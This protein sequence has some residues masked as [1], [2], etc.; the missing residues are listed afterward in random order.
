MELNCRL[1]VIG[2]WICLVLPLIVSEATAQIRISK[3]SLTIDEGGKG[4]YKL[5]LDA[6]PSTEI[7]LDITTTNSDVRV[8]PESLTFTSNGWDKARKITV[9]AIKDADAEDDRATVSHSVRVASNR[10]RVSA[11]PQAA[12]ATAPSSLT[13][14]VLDQFV[15][16]HEVNIS[17]SSGLS[18]RK[19]GSGNYSVSLTE[20]PTASVTVWA[21]SSRSD[22]RVSPSSRT[23]YIGTWNSTQSFTVSVDGDATSSSATIGHSATSGDINYQGLII[24]SLPITVLQPPAGITQ[25]PSTTKLLVGQTKTYFSPKLRSQ[26]TQTVTINASSQATG[27]ARVTESKS[28]GT[29]AWN[30]AQDFKVTGQSPGTTTITYDVDSSD[31]R[32]DG[33]RLSSTSV[34]VEATAITCGADDTNIQLGGSSTLSWDSTNANSVTINQGVGSVP[35]DSPGGGKTVTPP[36]PGASET[37]KATTYRF[38]AAGA[39]DPGACS[40]TIT[41]WRPPSVDRFSADPTTLRKQQTTRLIWATSHAAS[42]TIDQGVGSVSVD[43]SGQGRS[44][45]P[46][47]PSTAATSKSTSYTLKASNPGYTGSSA[48]RATVSVTVWNRPTVDRFSASPS[49][50]DEGEDSGLKWTTTHAT[51]VSIDQGVG[52]VS[53]DDETGSTKVSPHQDTTYTL[54]ASNPGYT[55]THAVTDTVRVTVSPPTVPQPPA[56]ITQP[57]SRT[58]VLVGQTKTYYSP[59]LR[60]QPTGTV[61]INASSQAAGNATVTGSKSFSSGNW[62]TAQDFNLTGRSVGTATITYDV[63][64]SDSRYDSYRLSSTSVTVEAIAIT[65]GADDTNIQLGGSSTLSW[66]STNANSVTINQGVGS[67]PLDSPGGGKTVTPPQPGASETSK[68]TTYRFT[69]A[70]A[71]DP[72]ACSVTITVWRP[73]SV[74]RFSADLTTLRKQQTTRLSWATGHASSTSI[75]QGIGS[76]SVDSSGGG[77]SVTP[78]QPST[79]ATSKSTSYTLTA[80][81]PGYTG[82]DAASATVSVTV[83]NRPSVDRFSASPSTIDEGEDSGLKWTTTHATGVSI[84]QG[85][86]SVSVDD[87]T[88]STKVSPHQDTTYTL[89]ASNPGYTGTHAVTDTVR[90]TVSP[91]TV[92]QP[93]AGITQPPSRTKV[94]VGQTKTYYSPA[95]RSQPTGTVTIN[96]SSQAAGNATVTGSKSF[97]SGNWNTAQDFNLTGRSVGTATITYDVDSSDSRYDGYRLSSTSVTVEATAITCG[98]DDTNIQLGGSSTLSWDSTNANS[99]TINQGVGSVPLDSPGGG[100]T[101]TPPQPGASETSKATTYRFTAAGAGDP[102][103]CSVTITVWRPPSVD[104]FSADLTT[105]R[106][107]QTT[108]LSWATGHA[109]STSINQGIGSVS[110]DSSGGGRSVTPLQPSTAATSKS[111]SYTLTA[112][113]PGYTGTDAASA[114]VSVT[115]WNRPTVDR[116]S[117][118]PSTIDEGEDSGLKWTT[119]HATGV[120][121]DQG[122]G[123][124]SVDDETGSTKVSPHQDTT[125]TL[126]ASNPGYTGT[127]AVTD[128][129][130]VTVSPPT[131]PQPPAGITQPPSRTKVLV[132][133]TKTYYSPALRSQPTGTVT[134]NASSQAAGNATVTGSKSFSSG[135]WN[136]AQDFNLTGRS[137]GTATITYDVDSSDSR[138][139]GYRLSSTSVTVEATAITCGADDTNIQLGGSSTLSWDSTNANSVTINQGVGSVPLDSPGGGKTVTPP[140]PGASETSKATT[141]RFTAAGAGDP[142]ACSVTITVWRRPSVDRFS[143]DPTT[144]RK[145]QATRLSWATSH[146]SGTSINQ[147]IGSVSV[148][149]SGGGRSVTPLQPSTAATSKRTSYTLTASNPGYAGTDATRATV[150]VTVWN[151]PSVDRFT[152][153]PSTIDEGEDSGLKWTT[154]H[155]TGVSIDQGVGPVAVDDET[156]TTKVSPHQDRTYTLTA[157]NPAYTGT[158]A[159]T[160]TVRV[161]VLPPA[162]PPGLSVFPTTLNIT[163]G[164]AGKTYN[165]RLRTQPS[166]DVTVRVEVESGGDSRVQKNTS[167][168]TFTTADWNRNQAVQVFAEEKSGTATGQARLANTPPSSYGGSAVDVTVNV[169]DDDT[170]GCEATVMPTRLAIDEGETNGGY[171]DVVLAASPAATVTITLDLTGDPSLSADRSALTFTSGNWNTSQRV[172][173]EAREDADYSDGR[174]TIGHTA[175]STDEGCSGMSISSVSVNIRDDDEPPPLP[176]IT[177]SSDEAGVS[178]PDGTAM[179]TAAVASGEEPAGDLTINL[180]HSGQATNGTDYTVATLTIGS[181]ETSDNAELSVIDDKFAEGTEE[182]RLIANA[183]GYRDSTPLSM[184]LTD[185]DSAGVT[186]TPT[187]LTIPE[188]GGLAY[189]VMLTS[190]PSHDVTVTVTHSGDRDIG[191][192]DQELTFTDSDW[193]TAR[194]VTVTAAQDDDAIDDTAIF[195]HSVASTDTDYN[196][197]T[198]SEVEVTVTDDETAGVSIAPAELS[199]AEGG[200]D[201]YE[202]VLTSKPSHEV[203]V[204]ISRSGDGDI[205]ID[206]QELT[207]TDSDWETAQAVTVSAAQDEDAIDDTA[208]FSHSVASTDTNYNRITVSEVAVTVTDDEMAGVSI[209][210]R[211][212]TIAEG[213]IDSYQVVLTSQPAHDVTI[214]ITHSG[215]GDIGIDDQELTFTDSDWETAQAVTVAAAQDD[216]AR[217]D[218]ATLSHSV[219]ST[220]TDYNGIGVSEV[221]VTATD[222]E[223]AGVSITPRQLTIAEGGIDS[224]QVVLTSQPAH[225][226]TVN[227]NHGGDN[228]IDSDPDRLTFSPSNWDQEKTVSVRAAQDDDARDDTATFS[229]RLDST[230]GDYNGITVSEVAVAVTDDETAGVSI[231]PEELTIAEGASDSYEVFLTSQ[232]SHDVTVTITHSRDGDISIDDQ[233]LTF[234]GSDWE[235]AQTVTVAAAQDDDARDDTATLSHSVASTDGDY[236]G[237]TVSEVAVAV[238]DDE[239]AGVSILPEELTIAEGASDSYEVVLT[240]QPAHEVTVTITH[241]GDGDI[242]I[243]DQELTFTGSDWETPQAVT[244]SAAQD[245]DARDAAA[246]LSHSVAS[247]DTDYNEIGVSEVAVAVTDDETAGVSIRPE[248]LTIAEGGSDS[249]QVVLTSKPAHDVTVTITHSGDGDINSDA[250]RLTFASSDWNQAQTVAVTADQDEDARDDA[251]TLSH[252]VASTDTDYNGITV[253]AVAVTAADDETAGVTIT[254]T[255]LTIAEGGSDAYQVVLTSQPS[256]EVTVTITHSGDGDINSDADRLT[257]AS[258]DW[259]QAQTVAVTADQD[260]DARDDAATLSHSVASTDTDYNGIGVSEVAVAVTDDE[261]AGVSILPEELTIAEGGSDAY[262]VVLTSQPA[263]EV[264]VTITHSGDGDISIGDQELTF[265]D[266]DW[267]T[268]QAVTVSADQDEDARDDTATLSHS[269]ASTDGDYNGITV[270]EVA[271]AVTDDETAGVSILPEELTIAEGGSD[272]YQ[273]FLMSQPAHD[274]TVT[275]SYSGDQDVSID[276][277]E[278]TFTGSDWETAQTVT[279]SAAQDDDARDDTAIL[280]H[281][282]ASTDTDYNGI[283]VSEVAVAVTDD[284]TAGVS[285]RPEE[286][287]IAEGA[288]DSY[289][290]FLTSQ[291]SHD[292]TVTITHSRDGDISIDDQELTFTGSD[293]ETAQ[294]VTVAAAQDDD[295]RD[296]T[297]TLSHSVASTDGDYNGITV[298]EVAVAVTDDET[299]GVSILPEELTIAEGASDSYEVVLTSQPAH[300]VTVTITHSGDGDISIDDQELTFTGSDWET[301]Q[302]VTVSAAQDDDARDAAATLSHSVAS[303]DTDYNEIGVSEVAVAVTDDETAGVSILPEEL[304]I[305]EGGSDSYQVVLTSKPAHDVTVT[306]THSG[307]GDIN[308]DADRLTFASSDWNQAQTVAVTADQDEDAR[309]DAATLSHSV[310]STD[311]DYNGIGV[312]EV[313]VAV[314]DDETAGVSILPEELTI[315]EGGSD[316]YQVVLTS[317]PAH[318]VTVTITHSGDGDISIGDQELTFT[319]SD[320]AT[321]QA[322]TVSADQD[323]DARDDTATLSHSVASTDGDYNG[324]TVSEVAVAVTDDE[325]A[326][327]SILPEELTIAEGGSDSYQVFLMSQPAHDVTVTISYSG[328]QDVSID[329]QELTFTGSDWETAQ[330]VTVSAAQD[331]DARDDTAILSHSVASTDTDYNGIGVSE[332]A[333]AVTDDETAGVSILP[334]ELTIAEG[335]SDSYQ[336]FL[337]SQPAHDVTVTISYSGD[338]DVSIDDQELTFTGSDWETAQTVTVSAAQDDDARD[339]TA[340]L[341]HSVAST[342]TDYNGIGVSEVAVAVTDDETAGVS[343]LPEE[344]TIAE[345]GSDSYQVVLTSQPAHKVTVTITHSGDGDIGIDDQEL[346]FTASNWET[347]QAVTVSADQDEDARDDTATLSHSVASTDGDYNGITVSEVAVAVTDDETAGV[348]I[349]P[350]ELT[351]AEGASDSYEVVLT[352]QPAHEVTVTITHSG[353]GDIS[354]DDQELTFTGS[355][356][357]TPQAVTVSAAQDDDAR[358]A[359]ATLSHSV[360]STDT[361]YNEIGVSEVAVAVT[362]D[363][364]AGVSIRPEEL[365]IAEGGSDSYQVVLTSKPAHDVT[366][367]ITHSGDGDINSDADRLTF[368]SSDWNQAQTVAVTADQD[369]DA[370][371]DAAT[372]SHSVASTDTDYNGITVSAVAVTAADD[373]TAGV[374]I[375]PTQLTIAEG[376]SDAYQVVLTSQPSHEVTVTITHSGDGDI[377]S[378]ADRLTFASSDWNQAQTVAVT[379]DQDEDARD[380]AATLSHSVASTDT[381]YN[382]IGVSEVA[383]AVTDDETAGVSILPEELTIAEGGSDSYQ[384]FLMSQPAHDVTVTISYSGDQ[385]VSIDDQELTFTGSDWET[386]QTVT[387]SAAQDDD[388]RDDSA[389]LSHSVASTDTD[390]NGITVS[391]VA[392]AVTDDETA[393]VSILP[394]EL[395]I[396]EGAS[397]SYEVVLT[398]QPA[399]EVTVTITHSGDGDI[400][401]DDQELA[402]TASDWETPQAVT[403]SAAQDDDARDDSATL[404]HSVSSTDGDYNGVTVSEVAVA[405]TDDETAGVSIRPTDLTIAEGGSDRY[406]VVLTSQPAHE[407]TVTITHSGDGDIGID[408]QELAFTASDWETP[409]AVT[410][411]AAQDDDAR[412]DTATLSHVVASADGDYNG[413][414]V[415]EVAVTAT[416]DETAG[417][418]I[419]PEE[420]T[421]AEGGSDSYQVVLTS[422]PAHEVTVTVTHSGDQDI[423]IGDQELTFTASD[424]ETPQ[425]VTVAAAQDDDARDDTATLS[426]SVSSTDGDYNGVT[427][428]AVNVT[429]RDDET[430]GVSIRPEELTIA[431]GGSDSYEVALTS[432]PSHEVTVTI[433]HGGDADIDSAPDRLTFSSSDWKQKKTV[434]VRATQDDDARDDTATLSHSVSSTDG[435][436]NGVTVS[437]VNVTVRDDETPGVSIRPEE[438]TIAEGGSDS[439]EVALTSK[440]SH[441]V[442]VTITH[443]G[444]ADIDSAPDRLTF[445]SSDWKQKKTVTVRAT[446]DDDARDDAAT[447]S[448]TVSSTDGDYNGI[449]VSEVAVTATDDETA[450]VS[451]LPEELTIAEGGSDSYQVVLTSQPAHEV[452]VTVTHSGDQDIGIGDQELTFTAS[453]WETPQAVTVAAAQDDDAREDTATLSHSVAS[454][455][456]DY[457]EISVSAVDVTATDDETAG[458]SIT[459][460]ELTI[461]EGG[462]DSYEVVLTSQPSHDVTVTISRSGDRHISID[463]QE[464]TFTESDW[465]PAEDRYCQQPPKTTMPETTRRHSATAWPAPMGTTTGLRFRKW[466]SPSPTTRPPAYRSRQPN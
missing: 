452:T 249:Y 19:G 229:H 267:A 50:I 35:L 52:S 143:A 392:V 360:A 107:Q 247:T 406:E 195:S 185:D 306:I 361:D 430:P 353:D 81:N 436:Y 205:G 327:V 301:P 99:V 157:S 47:Q 308:S 332:V 447:L 394:E 29:G 278:L 201:S 395:T 106:K 204:T 262:Q 142:G 202:V 453:N 354:I 325:T 418:S 328:D 425:A 282:V 95:L 254:P 287:T 362:D 305:A 168:L 321:P 366:V 194:T 24:D 365:T 122:V 384:V 288:S 111:T 163:E 20:R 336:V 373:E 391:E 76:V 264:T 87:E 66:D 302:A 231:R 228:D 448:H 193:E 383:V 113:N 216:D 276:D 226:V 140:Q 352:S 207:F 245:D 429:V 428:S 158:Q 252:S 451:I 68:A 393:G 208:T 16:S 286:L 59:A 280:S 311:T 210:P 434:T 265:T 98:A 60:S 420:L 316:A 128:T 85:V 17:P 188:G 21:S 151:R 33:Y 454:T 323:E 120:S 2:I 133:Q 211:Q 49:T 179:V 46:P 177:L 421:I 27:T 44:V 381:D 218:T 248:E 156:G 189:R 297:A 54:T 110:V 41:V 18:I 260:E 196:G 330:T 427:V 9:E 203:T 57:P 162:P 192:D 358:D 433:T 214:T 125:Y 417:V 402:F 117:A 77:R 212:L 5:Y 237:I 221:E 414:T 187:S 292:V 399:H 103:A 400:G 25:P 65:C 364:T 186:V 241:S 293:W 246:T 345:G 129:V 104:R 363:E 351:I 34:T 413:I 379:A 371:D 197:I 215:D 339:D 191:I 285:I 223:M 412:D 116:F 331:D 43:S 155:A 173:I 410:V 411:S 463:D 317:Q 416:D 405:V 174:A 386:A 304:T 250:D 102:G 8:K 275:I 277:Q 58:K 64:S 91:P 15:P 390:Y 97:S 13:V 23:F 370:R 263:H 200:S 131:V 374:T 298:S 114:T 78:L 270:S 466:T 310:A 458:V 56:G 169:A 397:D 441:E 347:A 172:T 165:V 130:R 126:T 146:A 124:V 30:T 253:S 7:T 296:D 257:F 213:G 199:I 294:T 67:V 167:S 136:T 350:E 335:G 152:A 259:N 14:I 337:M 455:D 171:Y 73:P 134:I 408:D 349:L 307:D 127:H 423:G 28:F 388:A 32:Y 377:N 385:D 368:A 409:Q 272:S 217:D 31:S 170:D 284:E 238:T 144:L 42:T 283:G 442:T 403:V 461:A 89:A 26:P 121:I 309:D 314:T 322:V 148:D 446:Q 175:S 145:Q 161:T 36:Q 80:S 281:S 1:T 445:S 48:A 274:V 300:E 396:A 450:G 198:V 312:S 84:D 256:H 101:V 338:Q 61:T 376:G 389:T 295:A 348:S 387:V 108:R 55:G 82:T 234:T 444:D 92:P 244:V 401:I 72:G 456:G 45:S 100:K 315:A 313:A 236:N 69:A 62:N 324:I 70:G 137:V 63:D 340:I 279:V 123:S 380:D 22:V 79:A 6:P 39:G 422:Q 135:N 415:S 303:T 94:L 240:S 266:S 318:E 438:L 3:S 93:P 222:D 230:D 153:S 251:A 112:S 40:V 159:V 443:G 372:L 407:V 181:G 431:E 109:S 11:N 378:D 342:D 154:T 289:E 439:Y 460:T 147:G 398:S 243:D 320:W 341:S 261:T 132:G 149:S 424:W 359:A 86:G 10:R 319:D 375:T 184:N 105:L 355:D 457:N 118:S 141:Y 160:D 138:Y 426:H 432:K 150:S 273:V 51:G 326:G 346:A 206:D 190:R 356:W 180:T 440:P 329:D 239:T 4:S 291:P 219:A 242:S 220:D 115:V 462:S 96:A 166:R 232:P 271:V 369:E 38:T 419:L 139:D 90:V 255:Q 74:D 258:S 83:W 178:E 449:T 164:A 343:I 37:S 71:G 290:V 299:A 209:T 357:E 235:T 53:V 404:S 75:N 437:A 224:Y 119:T 465:R 227:I 367:T 334:E 12:T 88:G 268:P 435:D 233:E 269:V 333:V 382:G 183:D 225:E 182:I 464:L 176:R 459:P 344:L